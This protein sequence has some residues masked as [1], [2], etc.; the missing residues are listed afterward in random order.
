[1]D[2]VWYSDVWRMTLM[3]GVWYSDVWFIIDM[4]HTLASQKTTLHF[5]REEEQHG[6]AS[7]FQTTVQRGLMSGDTVMSGVSYSDVWCMT[8]W[9]LV[10][11]TVMPGVWY[12]DV[13]CIIQWRLVYEKWCLVYCIAMSSA[14]YSVVADNTAIAGTPMFRAS[15]ACTWNTAVWCMILLQFHVILD[16]FWILLL[17]PG[18][19]YSVIDSLLRMSTC[20]IRLEA[21]EV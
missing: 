20:T 6:G 17:S 18:Y 7:I 8:H 16:L 21:T 4:R 10:Y 2:S 14:R 12:C 11:D 9:C 13:W 15:S 5:H 1:M 19:Y 3:F